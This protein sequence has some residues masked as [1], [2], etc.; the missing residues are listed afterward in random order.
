[1]ES[2]ICIFL[3]KPLPL[4]MLLAFSS[5]CSLLQTGESAVYSESGPVIEPGIERRTINEADIDSEDFEAGA[6][7][8]VMSIEDFGSN[9]V[10]GV[11]AAYHA[12]E[13]FFFETAA[14]ATEAGE[15]SYENLSG[16][17]QLLTGSQR[18]LYYYNFS[19]GYNILPG[20]SFIGSRYAFNS[21]LYLMAGVG[22]TE[23]ADDSHFSY[24]IG[25][26]YRFLLN[27]QV[28]L[29]LDIKDHIFESDLLGTDKTTHN[30]E[31]TLGLTTFF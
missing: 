7:I 26:G 19:L 14:G 12:T 10:Y 30:L 23:F 2:R 9:V 29:H 21:A 11:R 17:A 27:D 5:G 25:A 22:N 31:A 1:M 15:T 6:F 3:L 8:G 24:N 28:A 18:D 16:G 13:D 4:L 20:E